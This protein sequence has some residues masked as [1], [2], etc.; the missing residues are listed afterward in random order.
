MA[1]E[2]RG[3]KGMRERVKRE[4]ED[5]T[6]CKSMHGSAIDEHFISGKQETP[7]GIHLDLKYPY[8]IHIFFRS[9]K[10]SSLPRDRE[11]EKCEA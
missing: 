10:S 2:S 7:K 6:G 9:Q 8:I 11:S 4:I 5:T 1:A 3:R